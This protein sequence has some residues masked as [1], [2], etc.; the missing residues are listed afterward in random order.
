MFRV[1]LPGTSLGPFRYQLIV[2]HCNSVLTLTAGRLGRPP[3]AKV[4]VSQETSCSEYCWE[5]RDL[6]LISSV[7][8]GR[9]RELYLHTPANRE[10]Y[11]K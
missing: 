1:S 11:D 3:M 8:D 6:F 4:L 10:A 7:R 9:T 2:S 5:V